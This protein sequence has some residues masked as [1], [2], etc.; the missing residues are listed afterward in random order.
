MQSGRGESFL[1]LAVALVLEVVEGLDIG[2]RALVLNLADA[3]GVQVP[4]VLAAV[5]GACSFC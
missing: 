1:L 2:G 4:L 3:G 5:T